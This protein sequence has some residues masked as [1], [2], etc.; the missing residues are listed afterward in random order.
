[1]GDI[2]RDIDKVL[3]EAEG[4][5]KEATHEE[6][7][8]KKLAEEKQRKDDISAEIVSFIATF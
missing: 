8:R 5:K 2:T 1:M 6:S 4:N 7:T 3:R